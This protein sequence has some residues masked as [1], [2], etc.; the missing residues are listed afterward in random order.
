M[1]T[2]VLLAVALITTQIVPISAVDPQTVAAARK[3]C[4]FRGVQ[5]EE[6]LPPEAQIGGPIIFIPD[7]EYRCLGVGDKS[8]AIIFQ[9]PDDVLCP[10]GQHD[11]GTLVSANGEKTVICKP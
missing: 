1:R 4:G 2:L 11:D 6:F 9:E 7:W 10:S 3:E 8:I 5:F